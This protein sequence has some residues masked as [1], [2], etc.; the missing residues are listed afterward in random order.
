MIWHTVYKEFY[1]SC[2][3]EEITLVNAGD[4]SAVQNGYIPDTKVRSMTIKAVPDTGAWVLVINEETRA[5]LGLAVK[6][7]VGAILADGS[8]SSYQQTEAVEIHWKDRSTTQQAL[9]LPNGKDIL[10]GALPL[11]ALDL[12]VDPVNERLV[13]VHGD[14]A[15]YRLLSIS[16]EYA[17]GGE[18]RLVQ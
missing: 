17:A 5:K 1:M 18:N 3:T 13:G 6:D 15:L 9:L 2:F 12:M 4:V 8:A 7:S 10:L 11:E 16:P 14:K